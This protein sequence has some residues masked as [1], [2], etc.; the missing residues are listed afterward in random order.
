MKLRPDEITKVLRDQIEQYSGTVD[1]EEVGSR[2]PGRRRHRPRPR[3]RLLRRPRDGRAAPRRDRPRPEPR[4]GQRRHRAAG[5]GHPHQGGRR[6][7]AHR[8]GHPGAGGRGPPGPRGR[9]AGQPARRPRADRDRGLP[10]GGVQGAGRD[11]APAGEGAAADRHQGHRRPDPDRPRPARADHRRPPDRQDD[12]RGR[13]D[14]QPGRPGRAVLLRGDR[15]EGLD[16]RDGGR[17][18]CAR[19]APWTTRPWSPPPPP[20]PRR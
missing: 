15:P 2:P 9:P 3:P 20:R 4:G 8:Q 14:H 13:H 17:A 10:P 16:R 7:Q 5:R 18:G 1:V 11:P 6:G 19:P 12:D